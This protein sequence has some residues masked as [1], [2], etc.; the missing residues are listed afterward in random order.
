MSIRTF[1]SAK[2]DFSWTGGHT[3]THLA[4]S[5]HT[6]TIRSGNTIMQPGRTFHTAQPDFSWTDGVSNGLSAFTTSYG[7]SGRVTT[8]VGGYATQTIMNPGRTFFHAEPDYNWTGPVTTAKPVTAAR[9]VTATNVGVTS[10]G[11]L[12]SSRYLGATT[13]T[14]RQ[15]RAVSAVGEPVRIVGDNRLRKSYLT[16]GS[17]RRVG[18]G[19]V[20][21]RAVS[22]RRVGGSHSRLI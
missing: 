3:T 22:S 12:R 1:Y 6:N 17:S 21:A 13:G 5:Y 14:L 10:Y 4:S 16:S 20:Q 8:A 2:P 19:L 11:G 18:T 9:T 15:S 7:T